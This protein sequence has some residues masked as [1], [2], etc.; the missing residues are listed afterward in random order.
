MPS[1]IIDIHAHTFNADDIPVKGFVHRL[2][3]RG[4]PVGAQL[5][6]L[7]DVLIQGKAPGYEAERARL[8]KLLAPEDLTE[9]FGVEAAPEPPAVRPGFDAEVEAALAQLGPE[10]QTML[11]QVAFEISSVEGEEP[12]VA[13]V[14]G[15]GDLWKKA[16][17]LVAFVKLFGRY[18]I[19]LTRL[20][21]ENFSDEVDLYTPM[22]V[23]LAAGLGDP[24]S[25]SMAQQIE[26]QELIC[27]LSMQGRLPGVSRARVHPF[28]GFDPRQ[29][30]RAVL[31]KLIEKPLDYV[32]SAITKYGFVG[33]KLYPPM[34]WRPIGNSACLGMT[35]RF[36]TLCDD[37]LREFYAWCE[38]ENV[39]L[40]AHCNI[41]NYAHSSYKDFAG[42]DNWVAVLE[43][44]PRLRV[45]LGHFGGTKEVADQSA[46]PWK[47]ALATSRFEYLF[48]DVGNHNV[49]DKKVATAYIN[50]LGKMYENSQTAGIKE[51]IMFGSDWYMLATHPDHDRFLTR[52]RDLY[53]E[54]FGDDATDSFLG[55]TARRF[56][57]FD[58]PTNKNNIRLRARYADYASDRVPEWLATP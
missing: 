22:L 11:H 4:K 38:E 30:V 43:Q 24:P 14:E 9:G 51:R 50:G 48:A 41:S 2:F 32:K 3:L 17:L 18:R 21:I 57:G 52:Y 10:D 42:P 27:R 31:A 23:D 34:G 54:K 7:I 13:G 56:L 47:I 39:P 8:D 15:I 12:D 25:T 55:G 46:W 37:I 26:L 35:P 28:V 20:L 40:T 6:R 44:F 53:R 33:V 49:H 19:D 16:R 5:S 58:D 45:N 1:P 29:Q 36:A